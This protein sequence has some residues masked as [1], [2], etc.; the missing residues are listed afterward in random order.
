MSIS[1]H[2]T[3]V[4]ITE[5]L[6]LKLR[7]LGAKLRPANIAVLSVT[8]DYKFKDGQNL[9]VHTASSAFPRATTHRL[10]SCIRWPELSTERLGAHY[11]Y[12][13]M[14]ELTKTLGPVGK[15]KEQQ[16]WSSALFFK[17][18]GQSTLVRYIWLHYPC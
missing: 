13:A 18:F 8:I 7:P 1:R 14:T 9:I 16:V 10:E 4:R 6:G 15:K 2:T 5:S 17:C 11:V 3:C 12:L